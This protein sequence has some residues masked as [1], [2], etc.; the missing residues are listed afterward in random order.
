[1]RQ[2]Q[3]MKA[4]GAET[5]SP[6]VR[7]TLDELEARLRRMEEELG[8]LVE[9]SP[10][11]NQNL[12]QEP[13]DD[14]RDVRSLR[15]RLAEIRRLMAEG[16]HDEAMKL[17]EALQRET[18]EMMA[19]LQ[20]DFDLQ[21]P[22]EETARALSEFDLR[23]GELTSE[24]AGLAGE[25]E[26]EARRLDAE[27]QAALEAQLRKAMSKANELARR[28]ETTLEGIGSQPLHPSDRRALAEL[29]AR[30]EQ[31]REAVERLEHQAAKDQASGVE[32]GAEGLAKEVRESE[33]REAGAQRR[34]A[35]RA[36]VDELGDARALATELVEELDALKPQAP[37][38]GGERRK[39]SSRLEKRQKRLERALSGLEEQ[40]KGVEESLPGIGDTLQPV[41][42]EAKEAMRDAAGELK[43]VRPG[44]ATGPQRRAIERLGA[45]KQA[46]DKRLKDSPGKRNG[47]PGIHRR[48]Q[49][50]EI[51]NADDHRSP[52]AFREELLKAMKER[53]PE[54]YEEA[55]ERYYEELIR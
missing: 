37:R 39:Q 25:T 46:I 33:V 42:D 24:Q 38:P 43:E 19:S 31:A 52:R 21:A 7:R 3:E 26:E 14:E 5:L 4:K 20:G 2:L 35:L 23:L 15:E 34:D 32:T 55:I 29:E 10:Y 13:S 17:L 16:R 1:M 18:Q 6:E 50:V 41:M 11:E 44:D 27:A 54:R 45:M 40:L 12:S 8:K 22:R 30:A 49:R 47:G 28:L 53:A 48:D 36:I 51:P 9:R